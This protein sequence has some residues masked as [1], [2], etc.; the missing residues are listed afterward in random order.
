MDIE[1][2]GI[3]EKDHNGVPY[4]QQTVFH[5]ARMQYTDGIEKDRIIVCC[6]LT[7][8]ASDPRVSGS[9]WDAEALS[10]LTPGKTMVFFFHNPS[11]VRILS[12]WLAHADTILGMNLLFDLP[13]LR[14]NSLLS[15]HLAGRHTLV[16]LSIVN[17][18]HS[19]L[20]PERSLK[21]IGPILQKYSYE[22]S[23]KQ[24]DGSLKRFRNPADPGLASYA[25]QDTHNTLLGIA[26]LARRILIDYRATAKLSPY[27]VGYYSQLIWSSLRMLESGIPMSLERL[28]AFENATLREAKQLNTSLESRG[29]LVSGKGSQLSK[30]E[31]LEA[32]SLLT[33]QFIRNG[34]EYTPKTKKL[35][36]NDKNRLLI[37]EYFENNDTGN[38]D[39]ATTLALLKDWDKHS[40]CEKL[41]SSY[42]FPLLRYKR[43]KNAKNKFDSILIP[44]TPGGSPCLTGSIF[45]SSA[46]P[47][48]E[49]TSFVGSVVCL[50]KHPKNETIS[51]GKPKPDST[52]SDKAST[53]SKT[54]LSSSSRP[55]A[56]YPLNSTSETASPSERGSECQSP[57]LPMC[58]SG[59]G[60]PS[61]SSC[62]SNPSSDPSQPA[63]TRD[64]EYTTSLSSLLSDLS[65]EPVFTPLS[66]VGLGFPRI[67]LVPSTFEG[68]SE[69]GGQM[70]A[71]LSFKAPSVQTFPKPIKE[72]ISSRFGKKGVI[73]SWD[74]SQV[75]LRVASL[76]SGE[77][78]ML[79]A[80]REGRD[81]HTDRAVAVFG[82]DC[83]KAPDFSDSYRQPA[84]HANFTDLNLGGADVLFKTILKKSGIKVPMDICRF[85]VDSRSRVR[86]VLTAW[87]NELIERARKDGRVELPFTGISRFFSPDEK[88]NEI[89]NFPVQAIAA[90][91]TI[92]LQHRI[93]TLLP[94]MNRT[95]APC[96][97]FCN[98]YDAL[99]FDTRLSF[100]PTLKSLMQDAIAWVLAE[101]WTML[102]THLGRTCP[103]SY[104][105]KVWS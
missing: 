60:L 51:D 4:P 81:L 82:A 105:C 36:L 73:A 61:S 101:Y 67:Y 87:Q 89:V 19:E 42:T 53:E 75:E 12:R 78:S 93:H 23:L 76:L 37:T 62:H 40:K 7:V 10:R 64:P 41:L 30:L 8:A 74:A 26:E 69:S 72:C 58:A 92:R 27:S 34:L 66:G 16:D 39:A 24:S 63:P 1:T 44:C 2:Y 65:Q 45:L 85:I 98:W 55:S 68:S 80:Y 79:A 46:T 52:D 95:D 47:S 54:T 13:C 77:P 48:L 5:P 84:K 59:S 33:P 70:Q 49:S 15:P 90:T 21:N 86:P 91:L 9:Q 104:D 6:S 103:M 28:S 20:R 50:K 31:V 83:L 56:S 88:P 99:L 71:R 43:A 11:H 57:L 22:E 97:M 18:L 100:L 14:T 96:H 94:S 25:A 29:L 17:Y 38:P 32:A 3:C 102:E 35:A